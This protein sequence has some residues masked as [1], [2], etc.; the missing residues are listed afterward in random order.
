[1]K[2]KFRV[3]L[4]VLLS[5]VGLLGGENAAL[6]WT[7][8]DTRGGAV[9]VPAADRATVMLFMRADQP[10]SLSALK[11]LGATLKGVADVQVI[12]VVNG[13]QAAAQAEQLG[14][15]DDCHWPVVADT[16]YAASGKFS[17]RVWPTTVVVSSTGQVLAHL[18]G[19]PKNFAMELDAHAAFAAGR[20]NQ[21]EL[22]RRLANNDLVADNADQVAKR[23]FQVAQRLM[24]KGLVEAARA[25]LAE[26]LKL[27]P[28]SPALQLTMVRALLAMGD[29]REALKL[30]DRVDVSSTS[31][32]QI[33]LLRGKALAALDKWDEARAALLE[34]VKL[35]PQPAEAW[36]ELGR[37]YQH[38]DDQRSAADAFRRAFETTETGRKVVP[39]TQSTR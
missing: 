10:Q 33:N 1:M 16:D 3:A 32:A 8:K 7:G 21:A 18:A 34:A 5:G 28:Q 23:H 30:L 26:G 12:V 14:K 38:Q 2:M 37:V 31:P 20:I 17:V 35:N 36:Y 6:K 39:A 27:N 13:E 22:D 24:D 11:Q 4:V 25:E 15:S 9:S 19:L 29:S